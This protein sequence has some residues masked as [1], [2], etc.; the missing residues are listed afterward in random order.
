MW[1]WKPFYEDESI[2]VFCDLDQ[3]VDTQADQDGLY[4]STDCYQGLPLRFGVF[5][6]I[7]LKNKDDMARYFEERKK[8]SLPVTGYKSYRYSLCLAEI[9][10]GQMRSRVLPAGDYDGKDRQL[11]DTCII[12]DITPPI[13]AGVDENWKPIR[14]KKTHPMI[15]E[16]AKLFFPKEKDQ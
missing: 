5:I 15:R 11:G 16:L 10:G 6:S 4:C 1:N 12:T 14:S 2:S 13:F 3:I 8:R 7:V 9:D